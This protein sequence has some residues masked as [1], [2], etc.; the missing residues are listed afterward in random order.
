MVVWAPNRFAQDAGNRAQD[1][2]ALSV[3]VRV[4]ECLE[5]IEIEHEDRKPV[6]HA[7]QRVHELFDLTVERP[8]VMEPRERVDACEIEEAPVQRGDFEEQHQQHDALRS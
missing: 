8:A 7:R 1:G 5:F 3:S 6:L 4:V 2:I